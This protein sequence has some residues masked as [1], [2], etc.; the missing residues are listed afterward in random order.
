[1][2]RLFGYFSSLFPFLTLEYERFQEEFER[3]AKA[4]GQ[5]CEKLEDVVTGHFSPL[6]PAL[7]SLVEYSIPYDD[8][9]SSD[10]PS[11]DHVLRQYTEAGFAKTMETPLELPS[12]LLDAPHAHLVYPHVKINDIV[13]GV[14][15]NV[16]S[17]GWSLEVKRI[18]SPKL[19]DIWN[20][21]IAAFCP[22]SNTFDDSIAPV[23]KRKP[24][25]GDYIKGTAIGFEGRRHPNFPI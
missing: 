14:V 21:S 4:E 3:W 6:P 1:M 18:C 15:T 24:R 5:K 9:P 11:T 22:S 17:S 12:S 20:L 10:F 7:H 13:I 8:T 2:S 25:I 16:S 19:N 23:M